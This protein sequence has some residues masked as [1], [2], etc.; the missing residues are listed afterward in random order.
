M[1]QKE[2]K[3]HCD[4]GLVSPALPAPPGFQLYTMRRLQPAITI[5]GILLIQAT[6]LPQAGLPWTEDTRTVHKFVGRK[7]WLCDVPRAPAWKMPVLPSQCVRRHIAPWSV[8]E[9]CL[10]LGIHIVLH[11]ANITLSFGVFRDRTYV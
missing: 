2:G 10:L 1:F 6:S 11:N 3:E 7:R 9:C 4:N 5:S 8:I